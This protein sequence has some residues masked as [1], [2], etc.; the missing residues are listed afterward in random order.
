MS[1]PSTFHA[2]IHT[3]PD[4]VRLIRVRRRLSWVMSLIMFVSY[5]AFI[6]L[7][8]FKPAVLG[9]PISAGSPITV[10][11]PVGVGLIA[12]ALVMTGIY[13]RLSNTLFDKLVE[14]ARRSLKSKK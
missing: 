12:L 9:T 14:Q 10:G 3:N 4:Y 7:I 6:L 8:A 1:K 2:S 5:I 13:V 11:I